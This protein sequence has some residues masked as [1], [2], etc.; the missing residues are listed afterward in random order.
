[1]YDSP[2]F[3]AFTV[4]YDRVVPKLITNAFVISNGVVYDANRA[5]WDTGASITCIST[6]VVNKLSLTPSGRQTIQTPGGQKIVNTYLVDVSLPN[7]VTFS[8]VPVCD[9]EI[10]SQGLDV[11]IGMDLISLGDF[12]ITQQGGKTMFSFCIPSRKSIDFVA[13]IKMQQ[14]VSQSHKKKKK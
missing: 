11:L 2:P 10:G 1:M 13:Q 5:L 3:H 14:K 7:G 4:R 8:D 6:N 12:S 9:S